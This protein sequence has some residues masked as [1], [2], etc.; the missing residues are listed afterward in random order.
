[1]VSGSDPLGDRT[2]LVLLFPA[3][4]IGDLNQLIT[5]TLFVLLTF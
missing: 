5:E 2:W 3:L 4:E 1:M